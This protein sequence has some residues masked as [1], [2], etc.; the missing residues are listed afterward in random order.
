MLLSSKTL[1]P[2]F[3]LNCNKQDI[4][5]FLLAR[6][7]HPVTQ[8][9]SGFPLIDEAVSLEPCRSEPQGTMI[10]VVEIL[11]RMSPTPVARNAEGAPLA[12]CELARRVLLRFRHDLANWFYDCSRVRERRDSTP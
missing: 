3:H 11:L 8:S 6:M 7:P 10:A 1:Y 9:S 12:P 4:R 5:P 2:N